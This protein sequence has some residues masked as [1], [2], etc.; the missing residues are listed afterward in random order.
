MFPTLGNTFEKAVLKNSSSVKLWAESV[1]KFLETYVRRI[2]FYYSYRPKTCKPLKK[3]NPSRCFS[4]KLK[5][6]AALFHNTFK[7][8]LL[9]WIISTLKNDK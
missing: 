5:F 3:L 8:L 9:K 4:R 2:L 7:W 6:R 1:T